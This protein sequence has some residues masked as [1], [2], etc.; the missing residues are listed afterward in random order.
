MA[1]PLCVFAALSP[2]NR[3]GTRDIKL[4]KLVSVIQVAEKLSF[5]FQKCFLR[6]NPVSAA[7]AQ[8]DSRRENQHCWRDAK[9]RLLRAGK[10]DSLLLVPSVAHRHSS[11]SST[12][13][14][15]FT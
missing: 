3:R 2:P 10:S 15:L 13:A 4:F 11:G 7:F 8:R 12:S 14:V 9:T 6:R 5:R 1:G